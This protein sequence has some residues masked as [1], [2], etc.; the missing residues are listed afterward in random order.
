MTAITATTELPLQLLGVRTPK[1]QRIHLYDTEG[2]RLT[3]LCARYIG[4]NTRHLG[5]GG[6]GGQVSADLADCG[7]C[8]RLAEESG[9]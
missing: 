1:G 3:T 4:V 5:V 8:R 2:D 6:F 9:A 7:K